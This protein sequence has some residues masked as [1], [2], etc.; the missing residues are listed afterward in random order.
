MNCSIDATLQPGIR[1]LGWEKFEYQVEDNEGGLIGLLMPGRQMCNNEFRFVGHGDVLVALVLYP[2]PEMHA[3][4]EDGLLDT[5]AR[6][7]DVKLCNTAMSLV[8]TGSEDVLGD[9]LQQSGLQNKIGNRC[10]EQ[11]LLAHQNLA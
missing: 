7:G 6:V 3:T 10:L 9:I 4:F 2:L 1:L 5:P 11:S 8:S